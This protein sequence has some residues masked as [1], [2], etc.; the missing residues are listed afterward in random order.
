METQALGNRHQHG[1][2]GCQRGQGNKADTADKGAGF[3]PGGLDCQAALANAAETQQAQEPAVRIGQQIPNLGEFHLAPDKWSRLHR[4]VVAG[5]RCGRRELSKDRWQRVTCI[6]LLLVQSACP[7]LLIEG[8]RRFIRRHTKFRIQ[9][10]ATGRILGEGSRAPACLCQQAHQLAVGRLMQGIELQEALAVANGRF[11]LTAGSC[12]VDQLLAGRNDQVPQ[13]FALHER[14]LLKGRAAVHVEAVQEVS[15]VERCGCRIMTPGTLTL[16]FEAINGDRRVEIE[17]N[18][19][20]GDQQIG[21]KLLAQ[22]VKR[23][24]QIRARLFLAAVGP[25]ELCQRVTRQRPALA[26]Q[27]DQQRLGAARVEVQPLHFVVVCS[28]D[29]IAYPDRQ[30]AQRLDP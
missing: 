7:D 9:Y 18:T 19:L 29:T 10:L 1:I 11:K 22:A 6:P 23:A 14:P 24:T 20:A 28:A 21:A 3:P 8:G 25:E 12:L 4:K 26:G 17:G 2:G 27:I 13:P 15:F 16:Q 30:P 5:R